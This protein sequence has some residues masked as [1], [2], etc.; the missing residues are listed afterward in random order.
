MAEGQE[1]AN[2]R[3]RCKRGGDEGRGVQPGENL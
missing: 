1:E 2:G 3:I